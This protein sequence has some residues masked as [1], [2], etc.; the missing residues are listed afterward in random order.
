LLLRQQLNYC[1]AQPEMGKDRELLQVGGSTIATSG[2]RRNH[3]NPFAPS[4]AICGNCGATLVAGISAPQQTWLS[5]TCCPTIPLYES[6]FSNR[7]RAKDC[8]PDLVRKLRVQRNTALGRPS[9]NLEAKPLFPTGGKRYRNNDRS[10][11]SPIAF[12]PRSF[13]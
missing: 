9:K 13:G 10:M 6:S 2:G 4:A 3:F 7:N 11:A 1:G 8:R 5:L 12:W